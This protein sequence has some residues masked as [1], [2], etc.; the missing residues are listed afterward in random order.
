M[1]VIRLPVMLDEGRAAGKARDGTI[2]P[3]NRGNL[4]MPLAA[5]RLEEF[6]AAVGLIGNSIV[7]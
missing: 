6:L 2:M 1:D 7:E 3:C 5:M 4:T